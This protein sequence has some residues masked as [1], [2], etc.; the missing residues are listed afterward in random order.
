M[1]TSAGNKCKCV[2]I[3]GKLKVMKINLVKRKKTAD[4]CGLGVS[5]VWVESEGE[6]V[7]KK[8]M[9]RG[10]TNLSRNNRAEAAAQLVSPAPNSFA[11]AAVGEYSLLSWGRN[12]F[13]AVVV[14]EYH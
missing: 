5:R 4:F 8:L 14:A 13:D 11:A 7:S 10:D 2:L 3:V 1:K 9:I 12:N 6:T